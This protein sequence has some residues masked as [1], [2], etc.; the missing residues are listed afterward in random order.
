MRFELN[1]QL[2]KTFNFDNE[3]IIF[4]FFNTALQ[5]F[6]LIQAY[7]AA[8]PNGRYKLPSDNGCDQ[9][10]MTECLTCSDGISCDSCSGTNKYLNQTSKLCTSC[11]TGYYLSTICIQCPIQCT[12]CSSS[13]NCS[14][15]A[16][17]YI[18]SGSSCLSCTAPS[19]YC[20]SPCTC[21]SGYYLSGICC[22][23]CDSTC[24]TC[25]GTATTCTNL[26]CQYPCAD[27]VASQP[28][29]C[30]AC[31]DP[32][33]TSPTCQ[34][35]SGYIMDTNTH[36]CNACTFPCFTCQN[37]INEC[38]ACFSSYQ[39]DSTAHT[40]TCLTNQY[41]DNGS[42]KQCQN[43]QS[44]C[45]T[46]SSFTDCNS[47]VIG[48][49]R[50]L[51][52][53]SCICDDGYYD[54]A[55]ICTLCPLSC[56]KC[57]SAT[58]CTE[59]KHLSHQVLNDCH[60][61]DTYYMNASYMCQSCVSPCVNCTS[62]LD[63]LTCIDIKQTVVNDR[64]ICQDGYYMFNNL[65]SQCVNNCSKCSSD[66]ICTECLETYFLN[67][68][69]CQECSS[70]CRI[71][72]NENLCLNCLLG[73]TLNFENLCV[74]CLDNCQECNNQLSCEFCKDGFYYESMLCKKCSDNCKTCSIQVDYCLSC[75]NNYSLINNQCICGLGYYEIDY[76][77]FQCKHPCIQCSNENTC[78][79]CAQI[80][81]LNLSDQN[82]CVCQNG[83]Y[84]SI[85]K[86]I[87]C[88]STCKTCNETNTKCLSCDQ[89]LN[90][91]LNNN[92][93][94]CA[95][96]YFQSDLNTCISCDSE[97][98]K[99]IEDCKYKNCN[100]LVWTYGEECDDGNQVIG[101][102][103]SFCKI[104]SNYICSNTIMKQSLCQQCPLFCIS[105][106]INSIKNQIECLKCNSGYYLTQNQCQLCDKQCKECESYP[107]NCISCRFLEIKSKCK[108]CE[109]KQG[110]YSDYSN[111]KCY[112]LCGDSIISDTEQCDDGNLID[113]DGCNNQC[114]IEK[115]FKC[116]NDVCIIPNYPIPSLSSF[117][118]PQRY[119]KIRQFKLEYQVPLNISKSSF[120]ISSLINL[121]IENR[122]GNI[123]SLKYQ[124]NITQNITQ[125]ENQYYSFSAI[126]TLYLNQSSQN[127]FLNIFYPNPSLIQ[128]Y[129][130]YQQN[131]QNLKAAIEEFI[132]VDETTKEMTETMNS[133]SL[134]LFYIFLILLAASI[135]LGGLDIFYNLL[136]TIQLLSYLKYINVQFPFNLQSF[137]EIF[138]FA[139]LSFIQNFL[140]I[141]DFVLNYISEDELK[142]LPQ[143]IA[144]DNYSSIYL[145]NI[146]QILTVYATIFGAYGL[147]IIIPIIIK[148]FRFKYYEDYPEKN[149][150]G[151]KIKVYFLSFKIFIGE[152]CNTIINELFFSGILRT[153]MATAYD[154]SFISLLQIYCVNLNAKSFLLAL[155]S[156]MALLSV[157]LYCTVCIVINYLI[158]KNSLTLTQKKNIEQ[159]GSL[160]EGVKLRNHYQKIFNVALLVKKFLFMF[161][162]IFFYEDPLS[163]TVNLLLLS[164]LSAL[165]L[166][167]LKPIKDQSEYNKQL[168][169]ETILCLIYL[170]IVILIVDEQIKKF[171]YNE[172][173]NCGWICIALITLI[174]FIQLIIDI[175]QQWRMLLKKFASLRRFID[176]ISRML[177]KMPESSHPNP[178]VFEEI[179]N[180]EFY[181]SIILYK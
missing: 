165:Y 79:Q 14:A 181:Q 172:Q 141:D 152:M 93:C 125:F 42:P 1:N 39:Y 167:H 44:P 83:L 25:L 96:N 20:G 139:Q 55:G 15:C 61:I 66:I 92:Q 143:K 131:L 59:C 64:C 60:C 41:E 114:F 138:G 17:G 63:C 23:Q 74:A 43:C 148:Q 70:Q 135:L 170:I 175:I 16:S 22:H 85:D 37:S 156:F 120:N 108:I 145:I 122:S 3:R 166:Y 8:C 130:G 62:S 117:G 65:C 113:G 128:S 103:C 121:Y 45:L 102:G 107:Q 11:P 46:C 4:I 160:F 158:G 174:I 58:I 75:N 82:T 109:Y 21:A 34:C 49:N 10:C 104:D 140:E 119:D 161:V 27:C 28:T 144:N 67:G 99:L 169:T 47:C 57:T 133:F 36:M 146:S 29:N 94:I 123:S 18:L 88:H 6:K 118:K 19:T 116:Q 132:L 52:G 150:L 176:K 134:N 86:C 50:H 73:Y 168:S 40:C 153:F 163:Q 69:T 13:T 78:L 137:F 24:T 147:A 112:T 110:Y 164:L 2:I 162:L 105:C 35:I 115:N 54:N 106:Q 91:I 157:I 155:S 56:T 101:D 154:Y 111:N 68:S 89:S 84:W 51:Q 178:N 151:L 180:H 129:Q 173:Q 32:H 26:S 126:L 177:N 124:L 30:T 7:Q 95:T 72:Q 149:A 127:Q 31:I 98:G 53:N 80:Q 100:D 81:Y 33:Q 76:N 90:R 142:P 77:C 9:R 5:R 179:Q 171:D 97:Q 159:F 12:Q 87:Q 136:D 71:C 48:L 38:H